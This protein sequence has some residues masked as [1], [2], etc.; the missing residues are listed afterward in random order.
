MMPPATRQSWNTSILRPCSKTLPT[1]C[2]RWRKKRK[3]EIVDRVPDDN[4][5]VVGD[6]DGLIRLFSNL[7]HNAVKYT[8]QGFITVAAKAQGDDMVEVTIS[9]TGAGIPPQHLP[10]IFD[11]FLSRSMS[12]AVRRGSAWA[13]P[14]L[15]ILPMPTAATFP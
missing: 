12:R 7:L 2:V 4:L 14:L 15:L 9:D 3:L 11:R 6:S 8:Q 10:H 1:H 13:W 5:Y